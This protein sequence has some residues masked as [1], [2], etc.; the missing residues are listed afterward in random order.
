MKT[1]KINIRKILAIVIPVVLFMGSTSC[2]KTDSLPC[3]RPQG[4]VIA[5]EHVVPGTFTA[6]DLRLHAQ[7]IVTKGPEHKVTIHAAENLHGLIYMRNAGNELIIGQDHCIRSAS[8]DIIVEI[9]MPY[10][11]EIKISGSGRIQIADVFESDMMSVLISG[12]GKVTGELY[13]QELKVRISGSGNVQLI[14][15]FLKQHIIISGSGEARNRDLLCHSAEVIISGSGHAYV[16]A[17]ET[18]KATISGSGNI[19]Y[20]GNPNI[21]VTISGSGKILPLN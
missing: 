21:F 12:S 7:V 18:L 1:R 14:G 15:E 20:F 11:D 13:G 10:L 6:I 3:I 9:T 5:L 8:N 19:F 4:Q 16:N 2:L 17:L